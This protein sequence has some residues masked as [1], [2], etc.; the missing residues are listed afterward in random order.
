[1]KKWKQDFHFTQLIVFFI[2]DLQCNHQNLLIYFFWN[3]TKEQIAYSPQSIYWAPSL[4][5]GQVLVIM[6]YRRQEYLDL[7][8]HSLGQIFQGNS[9]VSGIPKINM[10]PVTFFLSFYD[11]SIII[12]IVIPDIH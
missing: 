9:M 7:K 2:K 8:D 6:G 1:M 3:Y 12:F 11:S 5:P 4:C 10:T